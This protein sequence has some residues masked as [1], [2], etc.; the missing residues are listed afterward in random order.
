MPAS[1]GLEDDVKTV[2]CS[3]ATPGPR[4]RIG[5]YGWLAVPK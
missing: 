4:C 2:L 3:G 5:Y 1:G